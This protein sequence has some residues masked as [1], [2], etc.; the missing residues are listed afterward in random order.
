VTAL[1]G[2]IHGIRD[3]GLLDSVVKRPQASFGGNFAYKDIYTM[4]AVYAQG[5]IKTH[6]FIDGNKR[7]GMASAFVF[8]DVHD[9]EVML[10]SDDVYDIGISLATSEISYEIFAEILKDY[11]IVR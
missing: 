5:I 3:F 2:G 11:V 10:S 4:A 8:L 1:F 9:Y 7:T 6:P